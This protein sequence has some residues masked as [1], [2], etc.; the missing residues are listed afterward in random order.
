MSNLVTPYVLSFHQNT[1]QSDT[2][3]TPNALTG[4]WQQTE[5]I[6]RYKI[7]MII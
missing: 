1:E 3:V 2:Y 4:S 6:I 7:T 5:G